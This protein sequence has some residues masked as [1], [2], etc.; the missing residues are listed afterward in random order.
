MEVETAKPPENPNQ[1]MQEIAD[2]TEEEELEP[3]SEIMG[4][5]MS[6]MNPEDFPTP[7]DTMD[8]ENNLG[9]ADDLESDDT[10][11]SAYSTTESDEDPKPPSPKP[12]KRRRPIIYEARGTMEKQ[13]LMETPAAPETPAINMVN[14]AAPINIQNEASTVNVNNAAPIINLNNTAPTVNVHVDPQIS[15][16]QQIVNVNVPQPV[17]QPQILINIPVTALQEQLQWSPPD[18]VPALHYEYRPTYNYQLGGPPGPPPAPGAQAIAEAPPMQPAEQESLQL[19]TLSPPQDPP[20][21]QSNELQFDPPTMEPATQPLPNIWQNQE[22]DALQDG[23]IQSQMEADK[24]TLYN[25]NLNEGPEPESVEPP[26]IAINSDWGDSTR[27]ALYNAAEQQDTIGDSTP[28]FTKVD[29]SMDEQG[30]Y[31]DE[32]VDRS[33][34]KRGT[35][36]TK[37]TENLKRTHYWMGETK[38]KRKKIGNTTGS[39]NY[40]TGRGYQNLNDMMQAWYRRLRNL[41][42]VQEGELHE[43]DKMFLAEVQRYV[44][45]LPDNSPSKTKEKFQEQINRIFKT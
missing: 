9:Q 16:P 43:Q 18:Q 21:A 41:P 40:I 38:S 37:Y 32:S 17:Y 31:T 26:P 13:P 15:I 29:P 36:W 28:S 20:P 4:E 19:P 12:P 8:D 6:D 30:N 33:S 11:Y 23:L 24:Y 22:E 34:K 39:D 10:F 35:T 3:A 45:T 7:V 42:N 14:N 2:L 44:N 5:G 1:P 27:E 25:P